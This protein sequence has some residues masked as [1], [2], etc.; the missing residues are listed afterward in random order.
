MQLLL[1]P[2]QVTYESGRVV[3][4]S[5]F[6]ISECLQ[7]GIGLNNLQKMVSNFLGQNFGTTTFSQ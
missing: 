4:S 5:S 6:G 2:F 1:T 7:D 3:I